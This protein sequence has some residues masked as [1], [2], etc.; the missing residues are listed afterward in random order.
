MTLT[1]EKTK[2]SNKR[3]EPVSSIAGSVAPQ[4]S[5]S[6]GEREALGKAARA[7][8]PREALSELRLS[9]NRPDPI[10]IL[11]KQ[12]ANSPAGAASHQVRTHAAVAVRLLPRRSCHH[13]H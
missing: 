10:E 12:A 9:P 13:G 2:V 4:N 11:E 7:A 1:K 8:T 6:V 5:L 3:G